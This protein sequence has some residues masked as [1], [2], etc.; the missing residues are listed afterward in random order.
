MA[1]TID[2]DKAV[3]KQ[4]EKL[5]AANRKRIRG[6]L[7]DRLAGLDDPR[8]LGSALQ[9]S[10]LGHYWRYRVGDYRIIC[11]IQDQRLIVLVVEIGHRSAIYR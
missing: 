4:V 3:R 2:Y 1:W 9:G 11:D 5:D 8:Q 7:H 10:E 6:F